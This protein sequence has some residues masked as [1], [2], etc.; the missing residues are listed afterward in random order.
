MDFYT[1]DNLKQDVAQNNLYNFF[2]ATFQYLTNVLL[3]Q[4][5]VQGFQEMRIDLVCN[6]IY[7]STDQCDFLLNL[8][9][10]DNPLNIMNGDIILYVDAGQID[11][12]KLDET[13]AKTLRNTYLNTNKVS[14]QDPSRSSYIQ[15]NYALPPTFLDV[16][17]SAVTIVD[18]KIVL[19][20]NS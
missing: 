11:F 6:D 2:D 19:G 14:T 4:Y 15:N 9:N 7:N 13:T 12:F 20:G 16:P 8:N 18:G 5:P 10:I 1:L 3:Y 17:S